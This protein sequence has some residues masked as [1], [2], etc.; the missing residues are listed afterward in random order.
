MGRL[1]ECDHAPFILTV[2]DNDVGF[3]NNF[4]FQDLKSLGLQLVKILTNQRDGTLELDC[5]AGTEF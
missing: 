5:S 4:Q 3:P 2:K 1:D